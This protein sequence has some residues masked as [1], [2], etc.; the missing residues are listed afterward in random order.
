MKLTDIVM[1]NDK[2]VVFTDK[3]RGVYTVYKKTITNIESDVSFPLTENGLSLAKARCNY[4]QTRGM[5]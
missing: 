5:K 4:L 1:E 2:G 3:K